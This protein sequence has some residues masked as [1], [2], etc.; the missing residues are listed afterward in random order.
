[1]HG[2]ASRNGSVKPGQRFLKRL[3]QNAQ[4]D[5]SEMQTKQHMRHVLHLYCSRQRTYDAFMQSK[6]LCSHD[7]TLNGKIIAPEKLFAYTYLIIITAH[8]A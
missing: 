8:N 7:I 4:T 2:K 5:H 6:T 3:H 1:M